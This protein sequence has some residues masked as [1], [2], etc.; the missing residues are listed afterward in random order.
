MAKAAAVTLTTD[1]W[2]SHYHNSEWEVTAI[3][4]IIL[5]L[6]ILCD[7]S[8]IKQL[9]VFLFFYAAKNMPQKM[10]QAPSLFKQKKKIIHEE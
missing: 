1:G 9:L 3:V 6:I 4:I 2:T 8:F 5:R 10:S 7:V